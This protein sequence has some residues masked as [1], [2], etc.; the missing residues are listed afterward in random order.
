M[1]V[2]EDFELLAYAPKKKP[3]EI[4][5][6]PYLDAIIE[7]HYYST[8]ESNNGFWDVRHI[9]WRSPKTFTSHSL[10]TYIQ[11]LFNDQNLIIEFFPSG[12]KFNLQF[13]EKKGVGVRRYLK[14][15]TFEHITSYSFGLFLEHVAD[16]VYKNSEL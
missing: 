14:S 12:G 15:K 11:T 3:S 16:F 1:N 7:Y 2:S 5:P 13:Y 9:E 10:A 4:E 6:S 8:I